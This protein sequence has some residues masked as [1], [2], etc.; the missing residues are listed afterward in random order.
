MGKI[1]W[2]NQILRRVTVYEGQIQA[3]FGSAW[4]QGK[5]A[6]L[7]KNVKSLKAKIKENSTKYLRDWEKSAAPEG[8]SFQDT[9]AG[10]SI[11][12][13]KKIGGRL[14]LDANFVGD[15]GNVMGDFRKLSGMEGV[16]IQG[17]LKLGLSWVAKRYAAYHALS[18]V[19]QAYESTADRISDD[20]KLLTDDLRHKIHVVLNSTRVTWQIPYK[21]ERYALVLGKATDQFEENVNTLL[22]GYAELERLLE[23]LQTCEISKPKMKSLLA[24]MQK[25][26]NKMNV[27]DRGACGE[28]WLAQFSAKL[29]KVLVTRMTT[30]IDEWEKNFV[31]WNKGERHAVAGVVQEP[32]THSIRV[33]RRTQGFELQP[34]IEHARLHWLG[35][36]LECLSA[37]TEQRSLVTDSIVGTPTT[38]L[39]LLDQVEEL[40][41]RAQVRVEARI[42][43]AQGASG[44]WMK[45]QQ[46]WSHNVDEVAEFMA[47]KHD[48][49]LLQWY[50]MLQRLGEAR[51]EFDNQRITVVKAP[52]IVDYSDV[53]AQVIEQYNQ[54]HRQLKQ[55]FADRVLSSSVAAFQQISD[56]K[57]ALESNKFDPNEFDG[58]QYTHVIA[59]VQF[60]NNVQ[61]FKDSKPKW[62][63]EIRL[64][65]DGEKLL[66][67][68]RFK[69]S[70]DWMEEVGKMPDLW[71]RFAQIHTEREKQQTIA[72][73]KV[74][75]ALLDFTGTSK[76]E[77]ETLKAKWDELNLLH[78]V[79]M[80][81]GEMRQNLKNFK[82]QVDKLNSEDQLINNAKKIL[83]LVAQE[84]GNT[85][86][87]NMLTDINDLNEVWDAV[88]LVDKQ[89]MDL[90]DMPWRAVEPRKIQHALK[91]MIKVMSD[92]SS[93]VRQYDKW[94][95]TQEEL[96]TRVKLNQLLSGLRSESIKERH[97]KEL[98]T[99][100]SLGH[101]PDLTLGKIWKANLARHKNAIEK[102]LTKAQ[103][104]MALDEFLKSIEDTWN[105]YQLELVDYQK[106]TRLIRGWDDLLT[107]LGE[108]INALQSM[109][110]SPYFKE[111]ETKARP[112]KI[113]SL[114]LPR[115][116][117]IP[118]AN[119]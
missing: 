108:H 48:D 97:Q 111:F 7:A 87:E 52:I 103:G 36:L 57:N 39:G 59:A 63:R 11:F 65:T 55:I 79:T 21:C 115:P 50:R 3:I 75:A 30:V 85:I 80:S 47:A 38:M 18:H 26:I 24:S 35:K 66:R 74:Q 13:I 17:T 42:T 96:K 49:D 76:L 51:D 82:E 6:D 119:A 117:L 29:D 4:K 67:K 112:N 118:S 70:G 104:E 98:S 56:A 9:Y 107:K 68:E 43:E 64:I 23:E 73:P 105:T 92:M 69:F 106:K 94:S 83:K 116:L 95:K 81:S 72:A 58:A 14:V 90:A 15:C 12:R 60:L 41:K 78:E 84:G 5:G 44:M 114:S 31:E 16:V 53:R 34:P 45:Y 54:W 101:W 19:L 8:G 20:I 71:K 99:L 40:I 100:M 91:E 25:C 86:L 93:N 37:F 109:H 32:I 88:E 113:A 1:V 2:T 46:L 33:S 27:S 77:I 61:Q 62:A 102:I 110:M 10:S 89:C 22:R 28:Q